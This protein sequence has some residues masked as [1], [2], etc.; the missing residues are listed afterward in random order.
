MLAAVRGGR[1]Q[2]IAVAEGARFE[3]LMAAA[4]EC[5]LPVERVP[6]ATVDRLAGGDAHGCCAW[7]DPPRPSDLLELLQILKG[8][9]PCLLVVGDHLEDPH[10]L[11]AI[12]RTAD[13]VGASG[14]ILPDRRAAGVSAA[15]ERAS[16]GALGSL[17]H[18]LVHNLSWALDQCRNAGFWTYGLAPDGAVDY[19]AA[20]FAD[21][22]VLVVG[23]EGRGLG[24]VVSAHC[25]QL[26][27][28]PMWGHVESLNASVAAGVLM[29]AWARQQRSDKSDG[30]GRAH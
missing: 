7:V 6:R 2:R 20:D 24:S 27:R 15:V 26:L 23:A 30:G 14:L 28:L 8:V 4:G 18:A 25:D 17:P 19:A 16:A 1:A 29:Y 11:G 9:R 3:E 13:G 21:R 22:A 5:G 12:A 10:N